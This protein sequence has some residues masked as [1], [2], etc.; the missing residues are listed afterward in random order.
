MKHIV[1][2]LCLIVALVSADSC[3]AQ[4]AGEEKSPW[5]D[6]FNGKDMDDWTVIEYSKSQLDLND[7]SAKKLIK[8]GSLMLDEGYIALQ[9]ESHPVQFRRS[10]SNYYPNKAQHGRI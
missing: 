5:I 8:D 1:L 4:Q 6:L 7:D 9:A 10:N 3:T 2:T